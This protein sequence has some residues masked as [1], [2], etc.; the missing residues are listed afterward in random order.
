MLLRFDTQQR[1]P[2]ERRRQEWPLRMCVRR[3]TDVTREF[4]GSCGRGTASPRLRGCSASAP[5]LWLLSVRDEAPVLQRRAVADDV[6]LAEVDVAA[7]DRASGER[8]FR[9]RTH[10]PAVG[11]LLSQEPS[12]ERG[13]DLG[14]LWAGGGCTR[15]SARGP[16]EQHC[17]REQERPAP[18]GVM[19]TLVASRVSKSRYAS[20]ASSSA[21]RCVTTAAGSSRPSEIIE[22]RRSRGASESPIEKRKVSSR[23]NMRPLSS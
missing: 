7:K 22:M 6:R 12:L 5:H 4:A 19:T 13:S 17:Q 14:S 18:H 16:E 20:T 1:R 9:S 10:D 21:I 2:E 11:E 3:T 8:A 23:S 15:A